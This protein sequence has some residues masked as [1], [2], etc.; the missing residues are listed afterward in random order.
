MC[1][2]STLIRTQAVH[3]G[4]LTLA[5]FWEQVALLAPKKIEE[6]MGK[7]GEKWGKIEEKMGKNG[8]S[9][10]TCKQKKDLRPRDC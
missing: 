4:S 10:T 1:S 3:I 9:S 5:F 8:A 7:N 2:R 6:K